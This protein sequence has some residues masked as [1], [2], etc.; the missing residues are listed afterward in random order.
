MVQ[1]LVESAK[2]L[3]LALIQRQN[4]NVFPEDLQDTLQKTYATL[5]ALKAHEESG[6]SASVPIAD[7]S[8][9][10][11]RKSI[12][13]RTITCLECGQQWRQLTKSHLMTHELDGRSYRAKYGFPQTWPLA[14]L[15]TAA[16][17]RRVIYKARPWEKS[18]RC[19]KGQVRSGTAL[20]ETKAEVTHTK[21]AKPTAAVP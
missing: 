3:T 1:S 14:S 12:T 18:P 10:D 21:T 19:R 8:P 7:S 4:G 11:W 15:N 13:R 9:V 5:T 2:E 20:P 16:R 17:R 6:T